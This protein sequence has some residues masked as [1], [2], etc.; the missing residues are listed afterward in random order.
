MNFVFLFFL[1]LNHQIEFLVPLALNLNAFAIS[2][3]F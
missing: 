1:N 3:K 2:L